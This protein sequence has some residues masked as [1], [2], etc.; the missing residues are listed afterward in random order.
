M[1]NFKPLKNYLIS[2]INEM[3]ILHKARS[4]FLDVGCGT[5]DISLNFAELGWSGQAIDISATA[6]TRTKQ[7]LAGFNKINVVQQSIFEES[8]KYNTIIACDIIEHLENDRTFVQK[9]SY[10]LNENGHLILSFPILMS[11]WRW[12]DEFYG[13][14]RRYE[15]PQIIE[16][17]NNNNFETKLIWDFTFP[18]FWIIRRVYTKIIPRKIIISS[19]KQKTI[20]SS[21]NSAWDYGIL[22]SLFEKLIWWKPI[23][24]MQKKFKNHL[25]GCECVIIAEKNNE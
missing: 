11:E 9:V 13:H 25:V 19:N 17:L 7:K 15:I 4:P 3:I 16:L 14:I 8:N 23:F 2:L 6:I 24:W 22:T 5:G 20:N 10:L 21:N 12:D 1:A 18:V